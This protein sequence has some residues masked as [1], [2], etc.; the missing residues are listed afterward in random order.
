MKPAA[1]N[2][3]G[4]EFAEQR[5]HA[6]GNAGGEE[7]ERKSEHQ[8]LRVGER[9]EH[10]NQHCEHAGGGE[11]G[12]VRTSADAVAQNAAGDTAAEKRDDDHGKVTAAAQ[13]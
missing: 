10:V 11:H 13:H 3:G 1:A 7:A 2:A 12:D 6:G 8:H 9:R 5:G 4:V